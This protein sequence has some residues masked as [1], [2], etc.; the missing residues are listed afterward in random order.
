M[1]G[2]RMTSKSTL[3]NSRMREALLFCFTYDLIGKQHKNCD[4]KSW[5]SDLLTF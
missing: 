5:N 4:V 1:F 3:E 2:P